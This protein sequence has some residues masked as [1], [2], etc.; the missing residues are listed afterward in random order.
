MRVWGDWLGR[1][2]GGGSDGGVGRGGGCCVVRGRRGL[3]LLNAVGRGLRKDGRTFVVYGQR[4][5]CSSMESMKISIENAMV[6]TIDRFLVGL[7][8]LDYFLLLTD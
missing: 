4:V 5:T 2:G 6:F 7:T 3:Q 8:T 1:V